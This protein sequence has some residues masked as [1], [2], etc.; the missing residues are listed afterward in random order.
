MS[1]C[2]FWSSNMVE[3]ECFCECIMSKEHNNGEECVF[4]EYL[5]DISLQRFLDMKIRAEVAVDLE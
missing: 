5:D 2:P 4:L 3:R 1:K